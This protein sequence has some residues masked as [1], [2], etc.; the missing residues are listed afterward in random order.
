M[1]NSK[2]KNKYYK[3]ET[4]EKEKHQKFFEKFDHQ[5][6]IKFNN[7][8]LWKEIEKKFQM[9]KRTFFKNFKDIF[10]ENLPFWVNCKLG[11][12]EF[13]FKPFTTSLNVE[14]KQISFVD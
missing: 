4:T 3:P 5:L 12:E 2:D 1:F 9:N 8:N 13:I 7:C 14:Q 10:H 6:R 11:L